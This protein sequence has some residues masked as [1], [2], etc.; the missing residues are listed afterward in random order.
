MFYPFKKRNWAFFVGLFCVLS[1]FL[2]LGAQETLACGKSGCP[3]TCKHKSSGQTCPMMM[4]AASESGKQEHKS[5]AGKVWSLEA[6]SKV[7]QYTCPMHPE[8]KAEKSGK[9]PDCGMKLVKADHYEVYA[10][11]HKECPKP[12]VFP[13]AGKCCGKDLQKRVMSKDEYYDFAQL[14][15]EYFCPMHSEVVSDKTGKCSK[16]GMKLE[17]RTV[18]KPQEESQEMLSYACPM[19]SDELSNKP[20]DCSKC[21]MKLKEKKSTPE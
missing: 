18:Q 14:Q 5:D 16:C 3:K 20:G 15:D 10:C 17:M 6:F 8:V 12:C 1:F 13:K 11:A 19:H 9:C 7:E 21:G 2:L 4:K